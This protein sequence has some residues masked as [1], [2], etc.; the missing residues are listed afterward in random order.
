MI[1]NKQ[2]KNILSQMIDIYV[3]INEIKINWK[4]IG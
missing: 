2:S 1:L 4:L 3:L